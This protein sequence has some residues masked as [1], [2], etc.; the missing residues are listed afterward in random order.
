MVSAVLGSAVFRLTLQACAVFVVGVLALCW[1]IGSAMLWRIDQQQQARIEDAIA[2]AEALYDQDGLESVVARLRREEGPVWD[3]D[4]AYELLEEEELVAVLRGRE[5]VVVA[6]FPG[7]VA[8]FGWSVVELEHEEIERPLRALRVALPDGYSATVALFRS[9]QALEVE[10]FL[11]N[12]LGALVLIVAPLAVLM[13]F[14][15]SW[16][17]FRRL[18]RLSA[19]AEAV[20]AGRM[21]ARAPITGAG[22]EFDRLSAGVNRML[23]QVESLNRNIEAISIGVAHDLK[24]PLAN[25]GGRLQLIARDVGDPAAV[26]QHL[27]RADEHLK[28]LLRTF[29]ALLRLG[30][31]EAGRRRAA[32]ETVD[33]SA[34]LAE[35]G[36]SYEPLFQ[37]AD[38]SLSLDIAPGVWVRG[39]PDL[40]TQLAA[41]LLENALEHS[42]D[43]ARAWL[44]LEASGRLSIGDDGPGAPA[45]HR[46]RLFERFFRVNASRSTPG[47]GLGLSLVK[48]IAD[49]HDA[50]VSLR[51]GT[52]GLEIDIVFSPTPSPS[53]AEPAE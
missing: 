28:T 39:D 50:S 38:K 11:E 37:D 21:G 29:D 23:D 6:G 20:A 47:N 8:E 31:V 24:T 25:L 53:P 15:L 3:S 41:N 10:G 9:D 48:A 42:R 27:E 18:E 22:D 33:L 30:E 43:G 5:D 46:D 52:P 45:S 17:V 14:F 34:R 1:A 7:L 51:P 49:L 19:T 32:F 16:A 44:R 26:A 36:D 2:A 13:G 12:A 4:A 35:L 40:L